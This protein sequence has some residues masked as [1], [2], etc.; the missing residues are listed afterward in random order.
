M[1]DNQVFVIATFLCILLGTQIL[2]LYWIHRIR[3]RVRRYLRR[4]A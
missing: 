3:R 2:Q 4:D 1:T